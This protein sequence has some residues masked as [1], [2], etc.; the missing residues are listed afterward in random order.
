MHAEAA[1]LLEGGARSLHVVHELAL[2]DLE[3]EPVGGEAAG[4]EGSSDVVD[5]VGV[6][7]LA[8]RE[9]HGHG[10]RRIAVGPRHRGPVVPG[11]QLAAGLGEDPVAHRHDDPGLLGHP[12]ELVGGQQPALGVAPPQQRLDAVDHAGAQVDDGLVA[13][14]ELA[15]AQGPAQ[16]VLQV[17][18]V[19]GL[20]PHVDLEDL[21]ALAALGLGPVHGGVGVADEGLG[22]AGAGLADGDADRDPEVQV[23]LAEAERGGHGLLDPLGQ[24]H[25]RLGSV[26]VLAQDD[27]LVA[28]EPAHG[29]ARSQ[30]VLQPVGHVHQQ[31][32]AGRVPEGVVDDL[33][34]VE[35]A[36]QDADAPPAAPAAGQGEVE[37]VEQQ[38]AVGQPG[39]RVVGRLVLEPA[40]ERLALGDVAEHSRREL[41]PAVAVAVGEHLR[42]HGDHLAVVAHG[43]ELARPGAGGGHGRHDLGAEAVEAGGRERGAQRQVVEVVVAHPEEAP[44]GGVQVLDAPAG[45][46]DRHQVARELEDVG[47]AAQLALGRHPVV[48]QAGVQG[49]APDVGVVEHVGA[50]DLDVVPAAVLVAQLDG[51]RVRDAGPG[52]EAG[53]L[54]GDEADVVGVDQ[55]EAVDAHQ[56]VG[57]PA[58]HALGAL[59]DPHDRALAVDHRHRVVA[60]LHHRAE[61]GLAA[62]QRLL[63]GHA[64]GDVSDVGH[65]ALDGGV[66]EAV[67]DRGLDPAEA[68]GVVA[69]A[70][71]PGGGGFGRTGEI[72]EL[73][74]DPGQV[75]G[76]DEVECGPGPV[77]YRR[78]AEDDLGGGAGI[79]DGAAGVDHDDGVG[80]VLHEGP[81]ALVPAA[82][83]LLGLEAGTGVAH[84]D[85]DA[86]GLAVVAG[87]QGAQPLH[88]H[89]RAVGVE[90][91]QEHRLV[92]PRRGAHLQEPGQHVGEVV[93]GDQVERRPADQL[94]GVVAQDGGG[95]GRQPLDPPLAVDDG[96]DVGAGV[97]H[98]RQPCLAGPGLALGDDAVGH[99][100]QAEHGPGR[101]V[102][103]ADG[104]PGGLHLAP[105]AVGVADAQH[106]A[107]VERSAGQDAPKAGEEAGDVVGVDELQEVVADP[108]QRVDAEDVLQRRVAPPDPTLR[109]D[110]HEAVGGVAHHRVQH[111]LAGVQRVL[112]RPPLG[113]V[114]HGDHD[115]PHVRLVEEVGADDLDPA[116]H[117]VG[118]GHPELDPRL[119]G[120]LGQHPGP[121]VGGEEL[122]GVEHGGGGRPPD[123]GG[124]REPE[125][126]LD[127][128]A[129]VGGATVGVH[130]AD[131]LAT[132]VAGGWDPVG[133]RHALDPA[134][135]CWPP[136]PMLPPH[137]PARW[138]TTGSYRWAAGPSS[139]RGRRSTGQAG[140]TASGARARSSAVLYV[141]R[142][143]WPASTSSRSARP[144]TRSSRVRLTTSGSSTSA[145]TVP[146]S[147]QPST[148][149][150]ARSPVGQMGRPR[151]TSTTAT[152]SG[153]RATATAL[154]H[155][156]ARRVLRDGVKA[157][158]AE[159]GSSSRLA[160]A[161]ARG[162]N[163]GSGARSSW[164]SAGGIVAGRRRV[165]RVSCRRC[166]RRRRTTSP[167]PSAMAVAAMPS[168]IRP[169][170]MP[171]FRFGSDSSSVSRWRATKLPTRSAMARASVER[172]A[173]MRSRASGRS[174]TNRYSVG[175]VLGPPP[176]EEAPTRVRAAK[177]RSELVA[178]ADDS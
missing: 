138:P 141:A 130:Q 31:A 84:A 55:V 114:A 49:D 172:P 64:V 53:Q 146:R 126:V 134:G 163:V 62:A 162:A 29:V 113:D 100:A 51:G 77:T 16:G 6:V 108:A 160:T 60:A 85:E 111:R 5:E 122:V 121:G 82:Q 170:T 178:R 118:A 40:L 129:H 133:P 171:P 177:V 95:A 161:E 46:G 52:G 173:S 154:G 13:K 58:E 48:D 152:W 123:D 63:G 27:E 125:Q 117:A 124:G 109:V 65:E 75:V 33:E 14:L 103:T 167:T 2:G 159:T 23:L 67:H 43:V 166:S 3:V 94:V 119:G 164:G 136:S 131:A 38:G 116:E 176:N 57:R 35:V 127:A 165:A 174:P 78:A 112:R 98:G 74:G 128:G 144:G 80:A 59:G 110:Q 24:A 106:G 17:E 151:T 34:V 44:G 66:L 47:E 79:G 102:L 73:L 157:P 36:E 89:R 28:A 132:V 142:P 39:E 26:D 11:D 50:D 42:Q 7:E 32:V 41:E 4:L 10:Q 25:R 143:R 149:P 120:G 156:L 21:V 145:S 158:T 139:G 87:Q 150:T 97:D 101:V 37:A 169:P 107:V 19:D 92:D 54:V 22:V 70:Q 86:V 9:V 18:A 20:L 68:V 30:L 1:Q 76:V 90:D 8:T 148:A 88:R 15:S 56:V 115:R 61:P 105:L 12:D 83:G 93:G 99:V 45:V 71:A 81:E 153:V 72:A 168:E 140:R 91:V 135:R 104:S 96:D 175:G 137:L 69:H 147:Q 155:P